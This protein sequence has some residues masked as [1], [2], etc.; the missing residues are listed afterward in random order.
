MSKIGSTGTSSNVITL[1]YL[2]QY[3]VVGRTSTNATIPFADFTQLN[4]SVNGTEIVSLTTNAILN[5][6]FGCSNQVGGNPTESVAV[7]VATHLPKQAI[8]PLSNGKIEN[9]NCNLTF[10]STT[11]HGVY[12]NSETLGTENYFWSTSTINSLSN[13]VYSDFRTLTVPQTSGE[14]IVNW[15]NGFS[16]KFTLDV[17]NEIVALSSGYMSQVALN[18]TSVTLYNY[19]GEIATAQYFNTDATT[20]QTV[21]V[22]R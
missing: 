13:N 21:I 3:L 19:G 10:T 8:L 22:N 5:D 9:V 16:D 20:A 12:A 2:P 6:A 15:T 17:A 1:N 11:D 4:V 18:G 14:L 7:G